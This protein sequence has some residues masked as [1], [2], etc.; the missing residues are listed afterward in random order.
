M[1]IATLLSLLAA[2]PIEART[3]PPGADPG[4]L[5]DSLVKA[6]MSKRLEDG[7]GIAVLT[8]LQGSV[9]ESPVREIASL[10]LGSR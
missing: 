5:V 1:L 9:P 6:E 2:A 8:N 4:R 10:Y 7:L 3:T